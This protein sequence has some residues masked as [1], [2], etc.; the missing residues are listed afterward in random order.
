HSGLSA[1]LRAGAYGGEPGGCGPQ[2]GEVGKVKTED[3][4]SSDQPSAFSLQPSAQPERVPIV[5]LT[6]HAMKGD[7]EMCI[8]AGM[9]D[10]IAKP[11]KREVV[12]ETIEKWVFS[13]ENQFGRTSSR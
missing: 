6:A 9:N 11:I 7:N 5:A 10:Y 3:G 13:K 12:F 2:A 1:R 4:A 8:E